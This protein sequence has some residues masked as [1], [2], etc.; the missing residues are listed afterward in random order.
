MAESARLG[1][2]YRA[3]VRLLCRVARRAGIDLDEVYGS[4]PVAAARRSAATE[5]VDV[6][7]RGYDL[8]LTLPKSFSVALALAPAGQR[9]QVAELYVQAATEVVA[10]AERWHARAT[11]GHHGDGQRAEVV[12]TSGLLGW[13][14]VDPVNRNGDAHWHAHCTLA[15]VGLGP[16]GQWSALRSSGQ[17]SLYGSVHALGAL[18]EAC[19]RALAAQHLG[20]GCAGRS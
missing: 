2:G 4:E 18:M 8:T 12:A 6:R 11:R 10:T 15:A 7:T 5:R 16:D 13:L 19:A 9:Q 3:D 1:D 14:S 20:W 17:D